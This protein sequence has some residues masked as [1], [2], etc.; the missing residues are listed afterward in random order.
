MSAIGTYVNTNIDSI[1]SLIGQLCLAR[2]GQDWIEQCVSR[3]SVLRDSDRALLNYLQ[4]LS[5]QEREVLFDGSHDVST[6]Y[7][8]LVHR[9]LIPRF[10][11]WL[12]EYKSVEHRGTGYAQVPH[13][14]RYDI[15]SLILTGG[16]TATTWHLRDAEILVARDITYKKSDIMSLDSEKIHSLSDISPG[17]RT[18]VIEGPIIKH[19]STAYS[20]DRKQSLV[21]PDFT[22]RWPELRESLSNNLR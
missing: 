4:E 18:L 14:H 21:F 20:L 8:W 16:Y 1:S 22:A 15:V 11:L 19:Y 12:H 7:K 6:H 2:D 17:T 10:T 3:L 5:N 9:N 13:D